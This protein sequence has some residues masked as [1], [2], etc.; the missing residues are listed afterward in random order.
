MVSEGCSA[1]AGVERHFSLIQVRSDDLGQALPP[2][3]DEYFDDGTVKEELQGNGSAAITLQRHIGLIQR[4][5]GT[6]EAQ[7]EFFSGQSPPARQTD[8][9]LGGA[10][11]LDA[12]VEFKIDG[13][14]VE[15]IIRAVQLELGDLQQVRS[16]SLQFG[17]GLLH[18][19]S[20]VIQAELSQQGK[21]GR[22][23][24]VRAES[25]SPNATSDTCRP[26]R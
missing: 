14:A 5:C 10:T 18:E 13:R 7:D 8:A 6:V 21:T 2:S 1:L 19:P 12:E 15:G 25:L 9:G 11:K 26:D 17:Q 16:Q 3:V 4:Q 24:R 22:P 23:N 20:P